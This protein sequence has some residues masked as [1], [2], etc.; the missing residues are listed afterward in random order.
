[1]VFQRQIAEIFLMSSIHG[2]HAGSLSSRQ[3]SLPVSFVDL[4]EALPQMAWLAAA[5]GA[6]LHFNSLWLEF[7]GLSL[8]EGLRDGWRAA[9]HAEDWPQLMALPQSLS[10]EAQTHAVEFRLRGKDGAYRWMQGAVRSLR[11]AQGEAFQWIGSCTDI[12]DLKQAEEERDRFFMLSLDML[13][14]VGPDGKFQRVNPAFTQTMGY[15]EAELMSRPFRERVHP[16]DWERTHEAAAKLLE[17]IPLTDLVNRYCT[18]NGQWRWLEWRSVSVPET[19]AIYATA[20]DITQRKEIETQLQFQKALLEAQSETSLDGI[21][22][23]SES[24]KILSYNQNFL[25]MWGISAQAMN[26]SGSDVILKEISQHIANAPDFMDQVASHGAQ[27]IAQSQQEFILRD[28]RTFDCYSAPILADECHYGRVWYFRD[29]TERKS[30][31]VQL[32]EANRKLSE[33][34]VTDSL[35]GLSNRRALDAGLQREFQRAMENDRHLSLVLLDV[36]HFKDYNDSFGH[37]AGDRV[38]HAFG[39]LLREEACNAALI[40][41]YGGEEFALVLVNADEAKAVAVA[42]RLRQRIETANWPERALTASFGVAT[43]PPRIASVAEML[44]LA[45]AALYHSKNQGRNRVTHHAQL[46]N[47]SPAA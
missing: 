14:I 2:E 31:E 45:D 39:G 1:V 33:L 24:G 36:D 42:Q 35:T 11:S 3:V 23:L 40:A 19:G 21:L 32:Q 13:G 10:S 34:A 37:P 18:K 46:Q 4:V 12:H 17:G 6:P 16:E 20:R 8:E 26:R 15:T 44:A 27:R 25:K 38:L 28:G 30:A 29:V 41:R 47:C 9:I 7:T 5:C 43:T 22:I